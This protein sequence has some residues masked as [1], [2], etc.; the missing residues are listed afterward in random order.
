VFTGIF[1]HQL[2]A[3]GRTALPARFRDVL[4]GQGTDKLI[5]TSDFRD[6]CLQAYAPAQWD[7]F[8]RKVA[9]QPQLRADVRKLMHVMVA[10]ALDCPFDKVGRILIPPSLREFA[11]LGEEVV[12]IGQLERIELWSPAAWKQ[13][14]EQDRT[15]EN[16]ASIEDLANSL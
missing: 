13:K 14:S 16:L 7:V 3:K 4:S 9:A 8:A 15:P 10:P 5:I 6:P 2:D 11:G 12:W 1:Q